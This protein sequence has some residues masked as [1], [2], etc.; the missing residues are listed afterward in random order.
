MLQVAA[1]CRVSTDK[2][3]QAN[4]FEAQQR[5][6]REYIQRQ[7]DW[8]LQG[9]Y[10]DEGFSGTSTNKRVEFNK[11]LHA[12]ELGQIDLIVTKEVSRFTRNTVDALQITRELRRRGVGVLF[13]NDSL[14]TR[15]NDGEL[16]L[17][18]M[19][20]VAQDESRK[21]SERSKWGQTRSMEKGVV[22]GG[23]LLGYD[24]IGGK[25]TVNPEGAEVVRLIFHKYLQ[26]RKGCSTIAR[27]LRE[28]G[29]EA[30]SFRADLTKAEE[31]KALIDFAVQQYG[32][33][34][35][36]VNN[37]GISQIKLFTDITPEEWRQMF[38]ANV[39]GIYHCC[40]AAVPYLVQQHSGTIINVSSIWGLCGASCEVHYSASKAAVIGFTQA[41]AKELAPSGITVNCV[42]PGAID[43]EMNAHLTAEERRMLE[44][45]IPLGRMGSPEEVAAAIAFLAGEDARYFTGQV[46]S[47]NGGIVI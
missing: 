28:A 32:H 13:L 39:D 41:L 24:V 6:F 15:T 16:R 12:A 36:L 22:F 20:S 25:M 19:S 40:R 30:V 35:I 17:T 42:A 8:E 23:S 18:I 1:Y 34:D 47:P 37:A 38:A 27:E 7:P 31:A 26:E 5:Y 33:L 10:A 43:T 46:L 45:E 3:D 14:D 21:T 44:E 29:G 9:I 11:M 2:E 4:S